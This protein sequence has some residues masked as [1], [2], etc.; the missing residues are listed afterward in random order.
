MISKEVVLMIKIAV[1]DDEIDQIEQIVKIV[2]DFFSQQ[3]IAFE[4]E[5]F[6]DGETLLEKSSPY[7]I[8]FLDIQMNGI[9]GIETASH[10]RKKDKKTALIYISNYSEKMAVSF[11]VHPFAFIEKPV[12]FG[13]IYDNL[14]DYIEYIENC[15]KKRCFL[16][17]LYHGGTITI[18]IDSILFLEYIKN[19]VIQL[20]TTDAEHSITGSISDLS[21]QLSK[22]DFISPHK[23]FIINQAHIT[24]FSDNIQIYGKYSVPVAKNRKKLIL[25]QINSYMHNHLLD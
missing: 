14:Y 25:Q 7:D 20:I 1:V 6:S 19:R 5:K 4:I 21:E 3:K 24:A 11:S 13:K 18:D 23:S 10:L 17:N 16:F 15:N 9:D 22:Y 2:S 12:N 8:I